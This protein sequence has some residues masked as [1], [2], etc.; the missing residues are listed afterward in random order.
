MLAHLTELLFDFAFFYPLL[1]SYLWMSGA[2]VYYYRY[3][4]GQHYTAPP[5]LP[6][7]PFVS[8]LVPCFNESSN[9]TET[10]TALADMHYPNYEII[11]INDGSSDDTGYQLEQL[12]KSIPRMRVVQLA[13]NQ[14]KA[15]AL[16]AGTIAAKGEFLVCVD[17]DAIL[18][19]YAITW[20]MSHFIHN[21][22][23]GAV[24]GNPR[25]R[26]RST[27]LGR[28][29]VGEFS[30]IVGLLKRAQRIY[31][32]LFTISGVIG[33]Y[34][35]R[36]LHSVGYWNERTIT[37]D[38]DI[39]WRLQLKHW[40]V[41]FE[42]HALCWILMPETLGG[43]FKQR[44]RWT[45]GG[46]EAFKNYCHHLF[47]WKDR[48]FW[49]IFIE[50]I[51]GVIWSYTLLLLIGISIVKLLFNFPTTST[52]PFFS[53]PYTG[54]VLGLTCLL[55]FAVCF[56]MDR[57]YSGN[58]FRIYLEIIWYPLFYWLLNWI[59]SLIAFPKA[60]FFSNGKKR[61]RWHTTDRGI[62]GEQDKTLLWQNNAAHEIEKTK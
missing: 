53:S 38:I 43:L 19:H 35:R 51:A 12:A 27:L 7:H 58:S 56:F 45:V 21:P 47:Y 11:A 50:Y 29:Q 25:I 2:L 9:V 26:T 42:P 52:E 23:V 41:Q 33:A 55:Q 31:G 15:V 22:R 18:D 32:R 14:G 4:R 30:A 54:L 24:T 62:S 39:S 36:A 10:F 40:N 16:K 17:G 6:E 28:I 46:G 20:I 3:E 1:M 13:T 60:M 49:G 48:R 8:V 5:E 57:K 44:L 34:R 59:V 61:G 37:E